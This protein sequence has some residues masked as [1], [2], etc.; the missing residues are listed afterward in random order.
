MF[1]ATSGAT[2]H[3]AALGSDLG[4]ISSVMSF[5]ITTNMFW[6]LCKEYE[7]GFSQTN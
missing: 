1:L 7:E 6:S 4:I 5:I 3:R 2:F